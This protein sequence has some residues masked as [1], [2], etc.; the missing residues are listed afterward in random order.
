MNKSTKHG[1]WYG[2]NLAA[3]ILIALFL[4]GIPF[5]F[6]LANFMRDVDF[7]LAQPDSVVALTPTT[8]DVDITNPSN[9]LLNAVEFELAYDPRAIL[10]TAIVPHDTLCE[11]QFVIT[12]TFDNTS[13]TAL[14]QCGTLTAFS[15]NNGTIATIHAIPLQSGTS[16]ITFGELT[17]VIAQD[18]FGT[19]ATRK[20]LD[21]TLI[22]L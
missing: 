3:I 17:H 18:G 9:T 6:A 14:F 8:I 20:R 4:V 10:V 2:F 11:E 12:N 19:D 16:T 7:S 5:L 21:L 22:T 15:G 13:G 1:F